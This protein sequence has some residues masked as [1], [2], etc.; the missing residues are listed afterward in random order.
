MSKEV[1]TEEQK[2]EKI[3]RL[4]IDIT[5]LLQDL[6]SYSSIQAYNNALDGLNRF[7]SS[8][9]TKQ[10]EMA[11]SYS[12]TYRSVDEVID[13]T[14]EKIVEYRKLLTSLGITPELEIQ[15]IQ[16][17]ESLLILVK[18]FYRSIF[19]I[20]NELAEIKELNQYTS[21]ITEKLNK[22]Y[23]NGFYHTDEA[24]DRVR[25]VILTSRKAVIRETQL[26]KKLISN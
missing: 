16:I 21:E 9:Q 11:L 8:P 17:L 5:S 10:L 14:N 1:L 15:S 20:Y 13:D 6:W 26:T 3:L 18:K 25:Q 2:Y 4:S 23:K 19:I 12:G 7:F 24:I 22:L